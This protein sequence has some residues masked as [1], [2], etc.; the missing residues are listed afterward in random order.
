LTWYDGGKKP[1]S[2]L[3]GGAEIPGN[4]TILV[5]EQGTMFV[6]GHYGYPYQLQPEKQFADYQPPE[7]TLPRAGGEH[8]GEWIAACKA[9]QPSKAMSNFAYSTRLTEMVLLGNL[10]VRAGQKVEWDA[11]KMQVTNDPSANRFVQRK[12]REGWS[13]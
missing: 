7:I 11:A 4:G 3:V 1:P 2:E 5:G 8:H 9:G 6:T 13:L 12:Y 10:A